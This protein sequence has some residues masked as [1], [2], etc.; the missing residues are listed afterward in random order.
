MDETI[1]DG[2][3]GN[4]SVI[5]GRP[6]DRPEEVELGTVTDVPSDTPE[7]FNNEN[8]AVQENSDEVEPDQPYPYDLR[9]LPGRRNYH[10]TEH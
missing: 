7:T 5:Q 9:P 6:E 4:D 10:P 8:D 2:D 1:Q 3:V